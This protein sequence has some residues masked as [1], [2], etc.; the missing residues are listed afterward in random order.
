MNSR[1][2]RRAHQVRRRTLSVESLESRLA[3]ASGVVV[4]ENIPSVRIEPGDTAIL[5]QGT[6]YA[7]SSSRVALLSL[8]AQSPLDFRAVDQIM[9][10]AD[11][12]WN[13]SF[14]TRIP[15]RT[16]ISNGVVQVMPRTPVPIHARRGFHF[17]VEA[18]TKDGAVPQRF[19]AADPFVL[20][21]QGKRLNVL[22]VVGGDNPTHT[23]EEASIM[24]VTE[25]T[26][27]ATLT[28]VANQNTV[29]FDA[30]DAY[31]TGK[32]LV[33]S[34][35]TFRAAQ[36]NALNGSNWTLWAEDRG[37]SV[38]LQTNVSSSNGQVVMNNFSNGGY[39]VPSGQTVRF[40]L[41]G[42]IGSSLSGDRLQMSLESVTAEDL[43]SGSPASVQLARVPQSVVYLFNQGTLSVR[44]STTPV[45]PRQ[46]LAGAL[47]DYVVRADFRVERE[48][49][50]VFYIG[51]KVRGDRRS[52]D[53]VEF[54][55]PGD[56]TPFA[57]GSIAAALV[58]DDFGVRLE[59]RQFVVT[60]ATLLVK[61]RMRS[62]V[63]GAVPG[64][65]FKIEINTVL[66]RGETSGNLY[67]TLTGIGVSSP[68]LLVVGVKAVN[69]VDANPDAPG[70]NV[71]TGF[72]IIGRP[73]VYTSLAANPLNSVDKMLAD[74]W[75]FEVAAQNVLL[76]SSGFGLMNAMD[77]SAMVR[78]Y[79]LERLDGTPITDQTVTGAFR[80]VFTSIR[81]AINS[82]IVSTGTTFMVRA[83]VLNAKM[84][85]VQSSN[86]QVTALYDDMFVWYN[87]DAAR[88]TRVVGTDLPNRRVRST[89]YQS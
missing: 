27:P 26:G 73:K 29:Y 83:N 14:E 18:D 37:G 38:I 67:P 81:S 11:T 74:E 84:S 45:P 17:Q 79:R 32:S 82:E 58:G 33:I 63:D 71:P 35:A 69:A 23:I 88:S 60:E 61:L 87:Q 34:G 13:G 24:L 4:L 51:L 44:Q 21:Y 75:G 57:I 56:T 55:R 80:V 85:S 53:R 39:I 19:G 22:D 1:F 76:S 25:R 46:L 62:D 59:N 77:V 6:M 86:L 31:V 12:D 78:T 20:A 68:A 30:F 10:R 41:T 28:A 16:W 5:S 15:S 89:L 50:D 42:D 65:Q 48:G 47:S 7:P 52:I 2:A 40:Y 36:G 72:V 8:P 9:L 43:E 49:A 3:L 70:T 54:Y 64:D 66:A